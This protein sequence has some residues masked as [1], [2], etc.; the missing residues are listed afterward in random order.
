MVNYE[1]TDSPFFVANKNY[2]ENIEA[3]LRTLKLDCTGF[4][5]SFGYEIETS[6]KKNNLSY[7][8]KFEKHQSTREG[9]VIPFNADDYSGSE[10]NVSGL[11]KKFHVIIAK[12][13]LRRFVSPKKYTDKIPSPYYIQ[14]NYELDNNFIDELVKKIVNDKISAFKLSE[15]RLTCKIH[16]LTDDPLQLL[17]DLETTLKNWE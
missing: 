2:C 9:G 5:N 8:I 12:S 11:N 7:N 6:L 10:I 1:T 3:K 17:A 15:G 14:A 16:T 13:S 4:C